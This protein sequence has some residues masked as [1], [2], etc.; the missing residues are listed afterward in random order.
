VK[1]FLESMGTHEISALRR[2][3]FEARI[4]GWNADTIGAIRN[5]IAT[6]AGKR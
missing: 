2:L 6:A 1:A 4:Y 3:Q 5:G